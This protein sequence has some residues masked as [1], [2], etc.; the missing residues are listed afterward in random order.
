MDHDPSMLIVN[1]K[2]IS[3]TDLVEIPVSNQYFSRKTTEGRTTQL[4]FGTRENKLQLV[5]D[6]Y[7]FLELYFGVSGLSLL[8]LVIFVQIIGMNLAKH[9][10]TIMTL[11]FHSEV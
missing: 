3:N 10:Q 9:K 5:L 7:L 11:R 6:K 4:T 1:T 8:I 2:V